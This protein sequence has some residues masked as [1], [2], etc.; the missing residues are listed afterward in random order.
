[1]HLLI[2]FIIL[3]II[4]F[5]AV[6]MVLKRLIFQDTTSAVNR[7]TRLDNLNREK[8]RELAARL[9]E[10][11]RML[12]EKKEEMQKEEARM[13]MEAER[14]AI[15]LHEDIV[16]NGKKEADEIVKKAIAARD[17][18]QSDAIIQAEARMID[19]CKQILLKVLTPVVDAHMHQHLI[20]EFLEELDKTDM[21]IVN[22]SIRQIDIFTAK[23][24][25]DDA[26]LAFKA[27]LAKKMEREVDLKLHEDPA[28]IGGVVLK[29]G[30]LVIDDS[31]LERLNEAAAEL[32]ETLG[33]LHKI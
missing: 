30:T 16:A 7:L 25:E 6:I 19:F 18:M 14:A 28:L 2:G 4:I 20:R 24:L 8:E 17:K 29:F 23:K 5:T 26:G 3:Q 32:K 9:E 33:L 12:R 22:K 31:L 13:K 21:G 10:T 15:K 11:E 27:L 1:M